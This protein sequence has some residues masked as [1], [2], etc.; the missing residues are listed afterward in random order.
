MAL[1]NDLISQFAKITNDNKKVKTEKTVY[2]TAVVY[3]GAMYVKL[4]G[5][6]LLTPYTTTAE[7]KDGDRVAVVIKNHTATVTGNLT[8]PAARIG[9]VEE[10]NGKVNIVI[11]GLEATNGYIKNLETENLRVNE[12]LT[13]AEGNIDK[14]AAKDVAIEGTLTAQNGDIE[15]LK[16]SKLDADTANIKFATVE[17]LDAT[18]ADI[19]NLE[20]DYGDFKSLA[21]DNLDAQKA[22]I[23]D[24]ATEKL[25][26]TWANIVAGDI[27][28]AKIGELFARSS[29]IED[30]TVED[31]TITG[32]LVGVHISG[33]L[34]DAHTIFADRLL[35][36]G[37]DGLYYQLN[38]NACGGKLVRYKVTYDSETDKYI[39]IDPV[40][41]IEDEI[42]EDILVENATTPNNE[43]IYST[44]INDETVY[45]YK[46][47]VFENDDGVVQGVPK[48]G[49]HGKNIIAESITADK[50]KVSDLQAFGANIAGFEMELDNE[51]GIGA[52]Y[53]VG[54]D[55]V[56]STV[57]GSYLDSEGQISIGDQNSYVRYYKLVDPDGAEI[58]DD[59]GNP[60]YKLEISADSVVFGSSRRTAEELADLADHI[61]IGTY[62]DPDTEQ[63][64][65]SVELTEDGTSD[66]LLMTNE[67]VILMDGENEGTVIDK[68]K[69]VT[70]EVRQGNFAWI[71]HG[72]GN[73]GLTWKGAIS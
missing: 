14:L 60:I 46:T 47:Y 63:Y 69:V 73:Y 23:T 4:D 6:D 55:T 36:Q 43:Q 45:Y 2:G 68:K 54:K 5:S 31:E 9:S 15:N 35:I 32:R 12:K 61:K 64:K 66:K 49:L 19:H 50:L 37:D 28:V 10:V 72:N 7:V 1:S 30:L 48:D 51:T 70:S 8:S 40:V 16:T 26:V 53:S 38:I 20:A 11:D 44:V 27:K 56:K 65:P 21:T 24:L 39:P 13:A 29:I 34:I 67:K 33:D 25:D 59:N 52:I 71:G 62:K 42:T 17:N 22:T 58:L 41:T 3:D 18:N 57:K